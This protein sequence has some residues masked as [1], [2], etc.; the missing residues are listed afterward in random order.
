MVFKRNRHSRNTIA[1]SDRELF[2]VTI[3]KSFVTTP[4]P[5]ALETAQIGDIKKHLRQI[6]EDVKE[7]ISV[8]HK[9]FERLSSTLYA[10]AALRDPCQ[11]RI[12]IVGGGPV[13]LIH[14]SIAKIKGKHLYC[15]I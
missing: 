15:R 2:S 5:S 6:S 7:N 4:R 9:F 14:A 12:V 13:G 8:A 10:N 11:E 1:V 3:P